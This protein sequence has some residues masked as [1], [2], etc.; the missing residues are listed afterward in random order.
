MGRPTVSGIYRGKDGR[1]HIDKVYR[2]HRLPQRSFESHGEAEGWVLEQIAA[3]KARRPGSVPTFD[4]AAAYYVSKHE[5]KVSLELDVYLL[6]LVVPFIGDKP[7]DQIDNETLQPFVKAMQAKRRHGKPLKAK[8]INL[9]LDRVRRILNLAARAWRE[10]GK[11]WLPGLP[12][13]ISMLPQDDE[14]EPLQ[15]TWAGQRKLMPLL[16]AHLARMALF[17]LNTGLRDEPLCSLRWDWEVRLVEL[18]FS[19]FVVPKRY[20]KGRKRERVVVC[21]SVAQSIVESVRGQ[22]PDFVFVYSQI[23]KKGKKPKHRP[24]E[25]MNNTAWQKARMR[26]AWPDLRVH[27]LRH[28]V[29]MRLREAGVKEE[30]I[31]DILWHSRPQMT[32]HYSVAQAVEIRE[33][34][35]LITDEKHANNVSL[36]SIIRAT[37]VP[38]KVP[39]EVKRPEAVNASG[40]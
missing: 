16:P 38:A 17:D 2:G 39:A 1:W 3:L 9:A 23:R 37:R 10:N 8:T 36:A 22:H 30:T 20:V 21:N 19:V 5:D 34:L 12:P 26:A 28:T 15:L 35:E 27:D 25:T 29:G 6:G 13:L 7:L 31:A 33:A 14:R 24:I 40:R 11:A 18:G 4:R 32:A